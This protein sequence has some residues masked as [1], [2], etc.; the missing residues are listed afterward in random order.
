MIPAG[1]VLDRRASESVESGWPV[2][3]AGVEGGCI[4]QDGGALKNDEKEAGKCVA[5]VSFVLCP[6]VSAMC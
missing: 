2:R 1:L 5:S 4:S 3:A 6:A